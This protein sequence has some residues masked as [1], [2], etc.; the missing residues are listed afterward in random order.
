MVSTEPVY[1]SKALRLLYHLQFQ[2]LW[3]DMD[4]SDRMLPLKV[5]LDASGSG[6]AFITRNLVSGIPLSCF[7]I[8]VMASY[9]IA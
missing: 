8:D 4:M 9:A 5:G 3:L 2:K 1:S 6:S 7:M